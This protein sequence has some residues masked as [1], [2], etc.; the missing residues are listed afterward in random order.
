MMKEMFQNLGMNNAHVPTIVAPINRLSAP[1]G[2]DALGHAVN[3]VGK[4]Q[5]NWQIIFWQPLL[6]KYSVPAPPIPPK[7]QINDTIAHVI[8]LTSE[9]PWAVLGTSGLLRL[10]MPSWLVYLKAVMTHDNN[11]LPEDRWN[12]LLNTGMPGASKNSMYTYGWLKPIAN[13]PLANLGYLSYAG[14][15]ANYFTA[16]VFIRQKQFVVCATG[17]AGRGMDNPPFGPNNFALPIYM[18]G[19][20]LLQ[21]HIPHANTINKWFKESVDG[22]MPGSSQK[23]V[24]PWVPQTTEGFQS[25]T[26]VSY[27]VLP[28]LFA[29]SLLILFAKKI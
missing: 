9:Y 25:I 20:A 19:Y 27:N 26:T 11:F 5:Y 8:N 21:K 22:M 28:V 29:L 4:E 2:N 12:I 3:G 24:D 10:D 13:H 14:Y 17:S 1:T 7:K 16:N 6:R 23:F 15:N 18:Q